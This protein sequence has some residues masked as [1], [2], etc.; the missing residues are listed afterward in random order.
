M[1]NKGDVTRELMRVPILLSNGCDVE[2]VGH[3]LEKEMIEFVVCPSLSEL[4]E[5]IV[6]TCGLF[7]LGDEV[8]SEIGIDR[9]MK[10]LD[11]QPEWSDL[12]AIIFLGRYP[13]WKAL[14]LIAAR[15]SMNLIQRPVKKSMF[16][17]MVR[18]ALELRH[19]QYQIRDLL[20]ELRQKNEKL[21]RRTILLQQ[22]ALELTRSEER[23][24]SRI[25]RILHDDLQQILVSAKIQTGMVKDS[26][27]GETGGSVHTLSETISRGIDISRS[28]SHEL[29]PSFLYG[30]DLGAVLKKIAAKMAENYGLSITTAIE[31][32]TGNVTECIK[33]FVCRTVQELLLNCVKHSGSDRVSLEITGRD[34]FLIINATDYGV[35]FDTEK[36]KIRGGREGGFGL[37]SIQERVEAL[38]GSFHVESSPSNG[39]RFVLN[40]PDKTEDSENEKGVGYSDMLNI[41]FVD[42]DLEKKGDKKSVVKVMIAD[43]HSV[44]RQGLASLLQN[45]PDILV[46]G[47]A[48]DGE[49]A[50]ELALKLRPDVV[51]MDVSMPV[52]NGMEATRRLNIEAPEIAVIALSMHIS[53][54]V[55]MKMMEAGARDYLLKDRPASEL[56]S[57]IR[58]FAHS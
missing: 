12:P 58:R 14:N 40:V 22:L 2:L 15:R 33:I 21:G 5:Q 26:L 27:N 9:L 17:I 38:G 47:E 28:L 30:S 37:F 11:E 49:Q 46:I 39:S 10:T 44:M 50:V 20:L 35:G 8:L 56:L 55:R 42:N 25:A 13:R 31:I 6:E 23:E 18:T 19:R 45:Q 57:A 51:L 36:L 1:K 16:N 3:V 41:A 32:E 24:R 48:A 4:L 54:E 29:N 52:L 43:D 7:I 53:D 34:N